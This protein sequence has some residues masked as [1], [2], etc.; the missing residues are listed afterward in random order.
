MILL[1]LGVFCAGIS[2][3]APGFLEHDS[4]YQSWDHIKFSW[5]GYKNVTAEDAK[6]SQEQNWW[7][8]KMPY[9]PAQ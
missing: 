2:S 9:I 8:E 3:C 1:L 6:K 7:G 4:S 5:A